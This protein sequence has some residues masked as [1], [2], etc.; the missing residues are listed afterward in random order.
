MLYSCYDECF[1]GVL[2]SFTGEALFGKHLGYLS[3]LDNVVV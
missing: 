1:G 3:F 2:E